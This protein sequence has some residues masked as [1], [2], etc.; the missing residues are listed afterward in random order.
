MVAGGV[1]ETSSD[2]AVRLTR[3]AFG[4]MD[5]I[6]RF[7]EMSGNNLQLRIGLHRGPVVAGVLGTTKFAYDLWGESVNLASR[8]ESGGAPGRIHVSESFRLG[9]E[10]V[11]IFEERGLVELKGVARRK[12]IG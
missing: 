7:S 10:D 3:C 11:M 6:K 5:I 1:P 4:M 2:H 8:L 9:L 12:H